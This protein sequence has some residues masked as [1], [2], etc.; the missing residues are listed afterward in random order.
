VSGFLVIRTMHTGAASVFATGVYL[1]VLKED[2]DGEL[3]F[4]ERKVITDSR[5]TDTLLVIPL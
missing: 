1:D 2:N 4:A 3:R 5:Q